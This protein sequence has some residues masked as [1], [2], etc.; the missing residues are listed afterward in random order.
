MSS[1]AMQLLVVLVS[2][3]IVGYTSTTTR[4]PTPEVREAAPAATSTESA[5]PGRGSFSVTPDG[6]SGGTLF[7]NSSGNTAVFTLSYNDEEV[8][9]ESFQLWCSG[10]LGISCSVQSSISLW[11]GVPDQ[12][13]VTFSTSS[14]TGTGYVY[15]QAQG[16]STSYWDNGSKYYT[17]VS[18]VTVT[19]NS[20]PSSVPQY[21]EDDTAKFDVQNNTGS[22]GTFSFTCEW[23]G[24][25]CTPPPN[26]NINNGQS[27]TVAMTFDAGDIPASYNLKLTATK[28]TASGSNT[29]SVSVSEFVS[30]NAVAER[31][32]I[33]AKP[34]TQYADTFQV[35]FPGQSAATFNMGVSCSGS[36]SGCSVLGGTSKSVGDTPVDVA[37]QY[38]AGS[39]G[40]SGTITLTATKASNASITA[41]G[42]LDVVATSQI[43]L[44]VD[45]ANPEMELNRSDCV[46]IA[47][48]AGAIVCDD[49]QYVYPFTPVAR[50]SKTRQIGLIHNS[51]FRGPVGIIGAN[52]VLPPGVA[53]PDSIR[54][55][56]VVNGTTVRTQRYGA[57]LYAPGEKTR[58]AFDFSHWT[59]AVEHL[60][61]YDVTLEAKT[62]GSWGSPVVT[63]GRFLSLDHRV[64][65]GRGWWIAGLEKLGVRGDTLLWTGAD[66]SGAVYLKSGSNWIRQTRAIP[67]TITQS[68]STYIRHPI[69]GG[70]VHF[71]V[72]GSHIRTIARNGIDT[73]HF[74]YDSIAVL[75]RLTSVAVPTPTSRDTV[76]KLFYDDSLGGMDSVRVRNGAG[77]WAT[78]KIHSRLTQGLHVDSI[79][80]PDGL[81]TRFIASDGKIHSVIGPA[82]DTT[83]VTYWYEKVTTV[84]VRAGDTTTPDVLLDYQ[85]SSHIGRDTI[86]GWRVPQPVENVSSRL[87]G[88]LSGAVDTT[89]FYTTGWG[90]VRGVRDALG[91][92]TWI[93]REN[94]SHP[95]LPTRV[96]YPNGREVT[97]SYTDLG[98]PDT[99]VDRSNGAL[100]AYQWNNAWAAATRITSPEGVAAAFVYNASTGN[101][102]KQAV[103]SDTVRF[104]YDADGLVDSIAD[105]LGHKTKVLRDSRGNDSLVVA[106]DSVWTRYVRDY[107][108]YPTLVSGPT[109]T[110]ADT[111]HTSI[112]YDAMG[113]DSTLL[114]RNTVDSLRTIVR[115]TYEFG[116]P[117]SVEVLGAGWT[118][119]QWDTTVIGVT[120]WTY[121]GLGRAW[122]V[123]TPAS[124]DTIRF[125]LAGGD[126]LIVSSGDTIRKKYDVLGRLRSRSTNA[127]SYTTDTI[128]GYGLFADSALGLPAVHLGPAD[129]GSDR[130]LHVRRHGEPTD[131]QQ[132][133]LADR[134]NVRAERCARERGGLAQELRHELVRDARIRAIV[135]LRPRRTP[136]RDPAS[137]VDQQRRRPDRV[138]L[139]RRD[140]SAVEREGRPR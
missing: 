63:S 23:G 44:T 36:L 138:Q 49:F 62:G 117:E 85:A 54:A 96:R 93:D 88:P 125:D 128:S 135:P 40:T 45:D 7:V 1:R 81:K 10:T 50:M 101:L 98:F 20:V 116:L 24:A 48:G 67:D 108:G 38:T 126:T 84:T 102:E 106:P 76:Y 120:Q 53:E 129:R 121:D 89:R 42:E 137:F 118:G 37:V 19:P 80:A 3:V 127:R 123:S 122:V 77:G 31:T 95:A 69:G 30:V 61:K 99:I 59:Q 114:T 113:R 5:P 91:N 51:A 87:D 105:P 92:E 8:W 132:R 110:S 90:A 74:G 119:S 13:T 79:T 100:T 82:R 35:R 22:S 21:S 17:I 11:T 6:A 124:T 134:A 57:S 27:A 107:R 56:L 111:V 60:F 68:G 9:D 104:F 33:Y 103:G 52:F 16:I 14:Q 43:L 83:A 109:G 41:S 28:S 86:G 58:I 55:T 71:D 112:S 12:V 2:M 115:S 73:T 94:T 65:Y 29:Q 66:A 18:P 133:L 139:Q 39:N 34:S 26:T 75:P 130:Y 78:F 4:P 46:N 72:I 64:R 25:S 136:C 15:L 97:T 47:A 140:R 32:P 131:G 70:A